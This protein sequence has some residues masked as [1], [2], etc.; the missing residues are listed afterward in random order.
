[1][2]SAQHA[3]IAFAIVGAICLLIVLT[4]KGISFFHINNEMIRQARGPQAPGKPETTHEAKEA[5]AMYLREQ[6]AGNLLK[7]KRPLV[8]SDVFLWLSMIAFLL[9]IWNIYANR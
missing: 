7:A 1:M 2:T 8:Y 3:Q 6:P 9:I 4:L 5:L